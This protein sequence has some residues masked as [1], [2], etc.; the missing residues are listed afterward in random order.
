MWHEER[1]MNEKSPK[2]RPPMPKLAAKRDW[3]EEEALEAKAFIQKER[4]GLWEQLLKVE[5]TTRD[6]N[7]L[8]IAYL[9]LGMLDRL[10]PECEGIQ[11]SQL[12]SALRDVMRKE[13]AAKN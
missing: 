9:T 10:H 5:A 13:I 7:D 1:A 11:T 4:P 3:K 8:E 2:D 12:F 6:F